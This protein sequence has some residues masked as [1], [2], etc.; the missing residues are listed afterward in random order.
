M[1]PKVLIAVPEPAG[2]GG[3]AD[4]LME[5]VPSLRERGRVMP[6]VVSPPGSL[7]RALSGAGVETIQVDLPL[8]S[9]AHEPARPPSR[10]RLLRSQV[11][12]ALRVGVAAARLARVLDEVNPDVTMSVTVVSPAMAVA[13]RVSRIPHIW[14]IHEFGAD[15]HGFLFFYGERFSR[16]FVDRFSTSLIA[17]S[18]ALRSDLAEDIS[19]GKIAVVGNP[20]TATKGRPVDP[21]RAGESLRIAHLG[22]SN[23]AKGLGDLIRAAGSVRGDVRLEVHAFGLGNPRHEREL[24]ELVGELGLDGRVHFHGWTDDPVAAVDS[25]HV[26]AVT[27]R[28]EAFGRVTLMALMRGRPVVGY[29]SGAT[30][31]LV[32]DGV[33]GLLV[34]PGDL[35]ALTGAL[36]RLA[37]EPDLLARL[38]R[39]ALASSLHRFSLS[40]VLGS[41]EEVIVQAR[42]ADGT[43]TGPHP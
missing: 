42:S 34:P 12:T 22:G 24:R 15:D 20:V 11:A 37:D 13:S 39:G 6:V 27:S 40:E 19:P 18:E 1:H 43:E 14:W 8:W 30:P 33:S 3:T 17:N 28:R 36:G 31:E 41:L 21:P 2:R 29:A 9:T 23:P 32:V 7:S 38:S 5:V 26:V 16:R 4:C 25:A 35:Q 10:G